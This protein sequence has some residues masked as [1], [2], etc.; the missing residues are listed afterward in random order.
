MLVL[1][2]APVAHSAEQRREKSRTWR[3]N[4]QRSKKSRAG[5]EDKELK[6]GRSA[7]G[8][9]KRRAEVEEIRR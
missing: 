2:S 1:S 3:K 9:K 5:E 4:K 7:Q 8:A 6:R